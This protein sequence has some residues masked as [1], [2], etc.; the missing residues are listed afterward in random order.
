MR[1]T[2]LF[3]PVM[4]AGCW[5]IGSAQDTDPAW[6]R[7]RK[8]D[9]REAYSEY[10]SLHPK[11]AHAAEARERWECLQLKCGDE[12]GME[13]FL[14]RY[15]NGPD[16]AKVREDYA[17]VAYERTRKEGTLNA[18][19]A[20]LEVHP[21]GAYAD[22][23]RSRAVALRQREELF[24]TLRE[25]GRLALTIRFISQ[26]PELVKPPD[27]WNEVIAYPVR[28]LVERM[29]LTVSDYEG[30][31]VRL[32]ISC[33]LSGVSATYVYGSSVTVENAGSRFEGHVALQTA[34]GGRWGRRFEGVD[35]PPPV[36]AVKQ[37]GAPAR[38]RRTSPDFRTAA[39]K[40]DVPRI[41]A[42]LG[43]SAFGLEYLA[44]ALRDP[45]YYV[46]EAAIGALGQ[47][48]HPQGPQVLADLLGQ[49]DLRVRRRAVEALETYW[50]P[51][52][53]AEEQVRLSF[54]LFTRKDP[55]LPAGFTAGSREAATAAL[56][57]A[58]RRRAALVLGSLGQVGIPSLLDALAR[59]AKQESTVGIADVAAGLL[60]IQEETVGPLVDALE[61]PEY[62]ARVYVAR[63]LR[64]LRP[65]AA[66]ESL[67]RASRDRDPEVR[68]AAS[69]AV[70]RIL[71][72]PLIERL[73]SP[74]GAVRVAAAAQIPGIKDTRILDPCI[75]A[76]RDPEVEVR[77]NAIRALARLGNRTALEP[78]R[79]A[80]NDKEESIRILAAKAIRM[81]EE[82]NEKEI[83]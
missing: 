60:R 16:A 21:S 11:G 67:R 43:G 66:L 6:Q 31:R 78:L 58:A 4:L 40:A 42:V 38:Q 36:W 65:E 2:F 62:P 3:V 44:D 35:E 7:A 82:G 71:V 13:E 45:D 54:F 24:R 64:V 48:K 49:G 18:Y 51:S 12:K 27:W 76:L 47:L 20:F 55:G 19:E 23:A 73:R 33:T 41:V 52:P 79:Q 56:A 61:N 8:I 22:L 75:A 72:L 50:Q 29:G 1:K 37:K 68:E 34:D 9:T 39:V 17:A 57:T 81:I 30:E 5:I 83:P 25:A 80:Q 77:R 28:R 69:E 15:P 46:A 10:L 53:E 14:R 26:E 70:D 74:D 63:I 32:E 59:E